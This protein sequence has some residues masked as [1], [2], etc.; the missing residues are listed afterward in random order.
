MTDYEKAGMAK[1]VEWLR[2][3][4]NCEVPSDFSDRNVLKFVQANF[5]VIDK[6][7][8]KLFNHFNWLKSLPFEP[9]LTNDTV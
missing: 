8:E 6:A 2:K 9:R 7:G 1:V 3:E 5:F 4:K